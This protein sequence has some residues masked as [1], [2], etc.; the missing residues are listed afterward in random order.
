MQSRNRYSKPRISMLVGRR[1][2]T[3]ARAATGRWPA[4]RGRAGQFLFESPRRTGGSD[5]VRIVKERSGASA[6]S[7]A[8]AKKNPG[9]AARLPGSFPWR[10]CGSFVRRKPP[11]RFSRAYDMISVCCRR[12]RPTRFASC[13]S[14]AALAVGIASTQQCAWPAASPVR[15]VAVDSRPNI[16]LFS[17]RAAPACGAGARII[18]IARS[19]SRAGASH[20]GCGSAATRRRVSASRRTS[21][22]A[23]I[24][25]PWSSR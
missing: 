23:S 21:A 22:P 9:Q 5:V 19:E 10:A 25:R 6:R 18:V 12:A 14:S 13:E 20:A 3:V 16:D 8:E 24:P 2:G 17:R 11:V 1:P 4:R 15:V 7:G